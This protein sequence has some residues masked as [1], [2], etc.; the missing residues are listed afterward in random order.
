MR[1]GGM[2]G[3]KMPP[4][5]AFGYLLMSLGAIILVLAMPWTFY[6]ALL[7]GLIGYVGYTLRDR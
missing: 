1:L 3:G 6:M 7:G 5:R 4:H 2:R